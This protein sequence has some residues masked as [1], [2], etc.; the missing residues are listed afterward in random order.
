MTGTLGD[1]RTERKSLKIPQQSNAMVKIL[2]IPDSDQKHMRYMPQH[3]GETPRQRG[4]RPHAP[5]IVKV[6]ANTAA[7]PRAGPPAACRP[8]AARRHSEPMKA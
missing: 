4:S 3:M 8:A 2:D 1:A 7:K 6:F 5:E